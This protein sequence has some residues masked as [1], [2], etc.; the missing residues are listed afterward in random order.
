M[1][2][3]NA[4]PEDGMYVHYTYEPTGP[5]WALVKHLV[6]HVKVPFR[7]TYFGHHIRALEHRYYGAP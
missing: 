1:P 5:W 4:H 3:K 2:Q 6:K 7:E